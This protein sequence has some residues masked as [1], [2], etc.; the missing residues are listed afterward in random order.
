[1]SFFISLVVKEYKH[2]ALVI[3]GS[4]QLEQIDYLSKN[5]PDYEIH[6]LTFT[7]MGEILR[8]LASYEN[9]KLHPT[10]MRWM[11]KKMIEECD[12]YLD[13][14]HE[15]KFP[16]VLEWVQEAKKTILT[17]DN[18]ANPYHVDHIFLHDKPQDMVDF[19]KG[20]K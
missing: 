13:I 3:T 8:S 18:V 1:L 7:E 14:N 15:F 2:Q 6:V 16:D 11:C 4:Q 19:L 12:V 17:F 9:I 5:L 20:I 10:V